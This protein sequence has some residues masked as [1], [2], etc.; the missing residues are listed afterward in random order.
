MKRITYQV[1]IETKGAEKNVKELN[2]DLKQTNIESQDIGENIDGVAAIGDKF[3]GGLISGFRGA[4]KSI[5][6][7]NV[8]FKSMKF[9]I[10]S[11]GIGA[12]VV[13]LGSLAAAFQTSEEG[14]NKFIKLTTVMSAAIG[15]L[16]DLLAFS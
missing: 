15:N 4:L 7:V 16:I 1:D 13:I 8:G 11:T 6:A 9:A 10:I 14:Q 5:K 12:L 2:K 3:T